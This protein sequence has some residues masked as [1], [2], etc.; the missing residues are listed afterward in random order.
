M[1]MSKKIFSNQNEHQPLK[2]ITQDE[3]PDSLLSALAVVHEYN[4]VK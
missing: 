4:I 1:H 2:P 3:A